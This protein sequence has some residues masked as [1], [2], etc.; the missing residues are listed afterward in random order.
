MNFNQHGD[1][2]R[3]PYE[4]GSDQAQ[5]QAGLQSYIFAR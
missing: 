1:L 4:K 5:L 2:Y 3:K